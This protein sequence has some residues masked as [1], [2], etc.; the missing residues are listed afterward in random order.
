M[1]PLVPV[2]PGV[3]KLILEKRGY[4][5]VRNTDYNWQ[6]RIHASETSA[7]VAISSYS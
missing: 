7:T 6:L 4:R 5:V 1:T 3:L 2:P